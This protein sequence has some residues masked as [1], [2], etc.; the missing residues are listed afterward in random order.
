MLIEEILRKKLYDIIDNH[1]EYKKYNI[2]MTEMNEPIDDSYPYMLP[3]LIVKALG[4]RLSKMELSNPFIVL[5]A[6]QKDMEILENYVKDPEYRKRYNQIKDIGAIPIYDKD[7][8][9]VGYEDTRMRLPLISKT[10]NILSMLL[11]I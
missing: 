8:R 4:K 7:G 5:Q 3:G 1:N 2:S 9:F 11:L 6:I 10:L